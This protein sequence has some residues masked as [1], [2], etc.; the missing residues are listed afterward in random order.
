[1]K[2]LEHP[3]VCRFY[4]LTP[5]LETY[6]VEDIMTAIQIGWKMLG[7]T[8]PPTISFHKDTMLLIAVGE[9]NKL[10]MI[11]SVLEQLGKGKPE[12]QRGA[13]GAKT[14]EPAKK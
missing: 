10:Q 8:N 13:T 7:E 6:K 14:A 4:Q 2:L 12:P 5:Y 11:D 9:H 3:K 1:V